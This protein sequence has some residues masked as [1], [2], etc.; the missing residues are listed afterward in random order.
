MPSLG[1]IVLHG[2]IDR[3]DQKDEALQ[4]ID[5]KTTT[6]KNLERK[7]GAPGENIQLAVYAYLCNAAAAFLPINEASIA[8]LELDGETDVEAIVLRLP[9]LLEALVQK[10]GL[11]AHGV[12]AVCQYCEVRGLCRKGMWE[13]P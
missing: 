4:V 13:R 6:R 11:T 5:Y 3:I 10:T 12:D 2:R 1:K 7:R 9:L 8:P